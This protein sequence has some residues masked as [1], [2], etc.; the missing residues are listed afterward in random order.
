MFCDFWG[1]VGDSVV[2]RNSKGGTASWK[3]KYIETEYEKVRWSKGGKIPNFIQL[4][5]EV[6]LAGGK[7]RPD[8]CWTN[9]LQLTIM[10]LKV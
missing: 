10:E 6:V 5:R 8:T 4:E 2:F 7:R 3:I 1:N 9:N